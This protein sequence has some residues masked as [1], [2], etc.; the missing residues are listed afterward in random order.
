MRNSKTNGKKLWEHSGHL[1][2]CAVLPL[3]AVE[4]RRKKEERSDMFKISMTDTLWK[5]AFGRDYETYRSQHPPRTH[6]HCA[7][8]VYSCDN[9]NSWSPTLI[10][11]YQNKRQCCNILS[12]TNLVMWFGTE[13]LTSRQ[14]K[15]NYLQLW[16]K[17][18]PK[19][20]KECRDRAK[21]LRNGKIIIF[22]IE[23]VL[24]F[25]FQLR[26]ITFLRSIEKKSEKNLKKKWK[27]EKV[28]I[29]NQKS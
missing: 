7:G 28:E 5:P 20:T 13:M 18:A 3:T 19:P 16:Q 21:N 11:S 14:Q 23:V 10:F 4:R 1:G 9:S 2:S 6:N 29:F 27:F 12:S 24:N 8:I 25:F 17:T 26:K 22:Y 15:K